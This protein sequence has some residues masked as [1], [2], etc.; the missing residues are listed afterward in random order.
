V[1]WVRNKPAMKD[2]Y[3][4]LG[5]AHARYRMIEKK[6]DVLPFARELGWPVVV[7]PVDSDSC[8]DTFRVNDERG[9]A[10][11]DELGSHRKWM[12]EEFIEG[13]EYQLC[14]IVSS[15]RVLDAYISR[16]PAPLLTIFDGAMNANITLARSEPQPV[17]GKALAQRIVDGMDIPCGYLHGEFFVRPNGEVCMGEIA[18]RLSGCEVPMNHGLAR[19]FDFLG[20][21]MDTYL[22]RRPALAYTADK[23][24]GDL[25]LPT[26]KGVVK[27]VSRDEDL[28]GLPGVIGSHVAVRPG[29]TLAPMRASSASSGYVHVEGPTAVEVE[30]RMQAVLDRYVIEL[31]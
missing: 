11:L 12:V 25:L 20:A 28:L 26:H 7:K 27:R 21:I 23:A 5:I 1:S 19:G 6:S 9:L 4:E 15:G 17:D 8:I 16:N 29:D 30:R 10:A 14:A 31:E 18:A 3:A 22:G 2:R 24:V 13:R